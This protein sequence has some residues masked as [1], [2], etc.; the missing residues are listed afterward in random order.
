MDD[1]SRDVRDDDDVY[2]RKSIRLVGL[3]LYLPSHDDPDRSI[4]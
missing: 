2:P 1:K 3:F 4:Q